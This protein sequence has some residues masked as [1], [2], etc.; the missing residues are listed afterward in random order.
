VAAAGRGHAVT[1]AGNDEASD[2]DYLQIIDQVHA[3][4]DATA[5]VIHP[6]PSAERGILDKRWSTLIEHASARHRDVRL[7]AR[8]NG[9]ATMR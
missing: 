6:G 2:A 3:A 1:I 5:I 9:P 4:S 8:L 7:L